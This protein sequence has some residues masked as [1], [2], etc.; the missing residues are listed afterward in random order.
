MSWILWIAKQICPD[1]RKIASSTKTPQLVIIPYSHFCELACWS[2]EISGKRYVAHGYA[3]AQHVLPVLAVRRGESTPALSS[4][5][6]VQPVKSSQ[7]E[8]GS[9][10]KSEKAGGKKYSEEKAKARED[11]GRSTAVP[12]L[13]QSDGT[14]LTDSW[15]IARVSGLRDIDE[16]AR[17]IYDTELGPLTRQLCYNFVLKP[18]NRNVWDGLCTAGSGWIW[19]WLWWLGVGS[20]VTKVMS[21]IFAVSNAAALAECRAKLA[22]VFDAI[23]PRVRER[24]GRFLNGDTI[25]LEDV[26]LASL[27]A[28]ALLPANYCGGAYAE[29]FRLLEAQD[30][31]MR[32][33]LAHWRGTEVGVYVMRLYEEFRPA[34]RP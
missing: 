19:R 32:K 33:E 27:A 6:F 14:V 3:P 12:L 31:D 16:K 26:A 30:A 8:K 24:K 28:P 5:S 11:R 4:S 18:S 1:F 29:W 22:S 9:A 25:G 23:A 21:K 34:R 17:L 13:V 7:V 2:L 10:L 20:H 15:S